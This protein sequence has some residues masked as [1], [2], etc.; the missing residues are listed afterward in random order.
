MMDKEY[1]SSYEMKYKVAPAREQAKQLLKILHKLNQ[2]F[3]YDI[4]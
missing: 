2:L 4:T 1:M 3:S